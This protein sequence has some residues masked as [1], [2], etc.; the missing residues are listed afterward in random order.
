M[1]ICIKKR[2][3]DWIAYV[4]GR[5]RVWECGATADEALGRLVRSL[6]ASNLIPITLPIIPA[7]QRPTFDN[8]LALLAAKIASE[9]P[10][11]IQIRFWLEELLRTRPLPPSRLLISWGEEI[12]LDDSS[13]GKVLDVLQSERQYYEE[14]IELV[15]EI[16]ERCESQCAC[17]RKVLELF[18]LIAMASA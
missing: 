1:N 15:R 5:E 4:E 7:Q 6:A 13:I 11:G 9:R 12:L 8:E 16:A 17:C 10:P 14:K 2:S 3:S 18:P